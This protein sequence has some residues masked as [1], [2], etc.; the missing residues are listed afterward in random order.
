VKRLLVA[1]SA[2]AGPDVEDALVVD[3]GIERDLFNA[4]DDTLGRLEDHSVDTTAVETETVEQYYSLLFQRFVFAVRSLDAYVGRRGAD[5]VALENITS[6]GTLAACARGP[7]KVGGWRAS[8]LSAAVWRATLATEGVRVERV[9]A[10]DSTQEC[11]VCGE[12]AEVRCGM[13]KCETDGCPV[14][15]VCWDRSAAVTPAQRVG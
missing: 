1:A 4:L 7:T 2:D 8:Q 6:Q 12:L 11:Y 5:V 13:I 3:G 9:D 10:V 15:V 14:N